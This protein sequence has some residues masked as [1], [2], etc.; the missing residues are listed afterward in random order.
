MTR[1]L[2]VF[3]CLT[4]G[5]IAPPAAAAEA[6]AFALPDGQGKIAS[7]AGLRGKVVFVDFWA[8]WCLPCLK[9]FPWL[10][11]L[12]TKYSDKGLVVVGINL[13]KTPVD[14]DKFLKR[15]PHDFTILYDSTGDTAKAFTVRSMPSSYVIDRGGNLALEHGGFR[16]SDKETLEAAIKAALESK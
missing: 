2:L 5:L 8:S 16:D 11:E 7:L 13:D 4:A 3:L 12:Q 6:P 10:S 9:S 1:R 14:A 15:V